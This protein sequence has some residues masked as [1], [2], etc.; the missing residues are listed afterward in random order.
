MR[1]REEFNAPEEHWAT[2]CRNVRVPLDES[3]RLVTSRTEIDFFFDRYQ[4]IHGFL[5][6]PY[7][8]LSA[9]WG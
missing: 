1:A 3:G 6:G 4:N 8:G 2:L 7:V 9:E 5:P